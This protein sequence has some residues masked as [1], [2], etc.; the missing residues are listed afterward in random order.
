[1]SPGSQAPALVPVLGAGHGAPVGQP[2][3]SAAVAFGQPGV[4]WWEAGQA[5]K[6][7]PVATYH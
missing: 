7:R 6:D 2:S 3:S 1:M 5:D 4:Q